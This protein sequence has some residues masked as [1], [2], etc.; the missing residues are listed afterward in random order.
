VK[1]IKA[2]ISFTFLLVMLFLSIILNLVPS[3]YIPR[4]G[5]GIG[6]FGLHLLDYSILTL[7]L[8]ISLHIF[9]N[10]IFIGMNTYFISFLLVLIFSSIIEISQFFIPHRGFEIKDLGVNLLGIILGIILSYL[11]I[12]LSAKFKLSKIK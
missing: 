6:E 10:K 7:F 1:N 9:R 5:I 3:Q 11:L 4:I 2:V 12:F 8:S